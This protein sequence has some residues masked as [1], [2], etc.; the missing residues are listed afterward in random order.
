VRL[1]AKITQSEVAADFKMPVPIYLDF[2][3]RVVRAGSILL[4]G[5]M[6]TQ[7]ILLDLPKRPKRVLLSANHDVLAAETI[8]K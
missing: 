3:G 7:E 4:H 2:D 6:T 5:N 1:S 8:I